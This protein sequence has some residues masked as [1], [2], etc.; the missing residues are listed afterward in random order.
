MGKRTKVARYNRYIQFYKA[1]ETE[2]EYDSGGNLIPKME[3]YKKRWCNKK[4]LVRANQ[5]SLESAA[6]IASKFVRLTT[7]FTNV[8]TE[9]MQFEVDGQMFNV[10]MVGDADGLNIETVIS[11]EATADGGR[12]ES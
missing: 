10:K 11:G 7:R 2:W 3:P 8:I 9:N 12:N 6:D 1:S 4:D 5:E